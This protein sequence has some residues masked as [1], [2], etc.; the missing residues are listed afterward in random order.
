MSWAHELGGEHPLDRHLLLAMGRL[1]IAPL[2]FESYF[3]E[4]ASPLA[5]CD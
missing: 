2:P 4:L 5:M 3:S 1:L